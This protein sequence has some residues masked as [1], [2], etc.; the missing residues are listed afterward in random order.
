M[1]TI[2]NWRV[3]MTRRRMLLFAVV[4][5]ALIAGSILLA[6]WAWPKWGIWPVA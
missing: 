6:S 1:T 3:K 4:A 2:G 5:V